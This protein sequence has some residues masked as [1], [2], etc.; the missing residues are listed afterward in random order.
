MS[1]SERGKK[2]TPKVFPFPQPELFSGR[3]FGKRVGKKP[4]SQEGFRMPEPSLTHTELSR[5]VSGGGR[6]TRSIQHESL[7]WTPCICC[8]SLPLSK[9]PFGVPC[10]APGPA[11]R[12]GAPTS[13]T[14]V[15]F[16]MSAFREEASSN[17]LPPSSRQDSAKD[18][19]GPRRVEVWGVALLA[20]VK[21]QPQRFPNRFFMAV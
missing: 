19:A 12:G 6:R 18:S 21:P 9:M 1:V 11:Q 17:T 14:R 4:L 3:S 7:L 10:A 20:F 15:L 5:D 16:P 13:S 8:E 2:W